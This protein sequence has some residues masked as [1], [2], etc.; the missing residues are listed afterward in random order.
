MVEYHFYITGDLA[1]EDVEVV[2]NRLNEADQGYELKEI[3]SEQ[4]TGWGTFN[5]TI[6]ICSNV[7]EKILLCDLEEAFEQFS[8]T[9][10][11]LEERSPVYRKVATW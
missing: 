10:Q 8:G 7:D 9:C 6:P 11:M 4:I 1:S 5:H 2:L 3:L